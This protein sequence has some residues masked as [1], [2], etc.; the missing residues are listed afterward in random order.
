M[1][2]TSFFRLLCFPIMISISGF[3][4]VTQQGSNTEYLKE[5]NTIVEPNQS[6]IL[7]ENVR[8]IDGKGSSP[9]EKGYV[10]VKNGII[11]AVEPGEIPR[12]KR[13]HKKTVDG[14]GRSLLPGLI[15]AHFHSINNNEFLQLI[16][17]NGVTTLRDPGHP[18]T[19]Y[20][21]IN[22]TDKP[23]PRIFLTGAHLD[24]P[25]A[26]Y[27]QQATLVKSHDHARQMV[28]NYAKNGATAVKIYFRLPLKYYK[29]VV[30]TADSYKIPVIAHLEL[31]SAVDAIS[32]GVKGIE[33]VTSFGTSVA[34]EEMR[35][36]FE[37]KVEQDNN[38]RGNERYRLWASLDMNSPKIKEVIDFARKKDIVICPTLATF[39][40]QVDSL[41]AEDYRVK[42]FRNMVK[43]VE[44]AHKA[45]VKIV[46]ASHSSSL[47]SKHGWTYQREME[48]LN[49]AGMT[50]LEVIKSSTVLNAAYFGNSSRLGSIEVG[51][52]ADLILVN[53]NPATDIK[54]M[55]NIDAVMLNGIWIN[56]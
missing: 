42:G 39:E 5:F 49:I 55:Y 33:H 40:R 25:P 32:T 12:E 35:K 16:L 28:H 27:G 4:Q 6:E 36:S 34:D 41:G 23:L 2:T 56:K 30:E 54:A 21:A 3:S 15:D 18:F 7:I 29:D 17:N 9:V 8:I 43:F 10:I 53:G 14:K 26:A 44:L 51:K 47:Y 1:I 37:K 50:P 46:A 38:A 31:V 11:T 19:F 22:F 24:Y 48:L 52:A 20:Q 13:V 45:G